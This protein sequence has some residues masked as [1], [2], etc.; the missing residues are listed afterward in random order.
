MIA[1]STSLRRNKKVAGVEDP[2]VIIQ[3]LLNIFRQLHILNDAQKA[4]FN[5]MIL[6]QPA[7]IRHMCNILPGGSLLQ[8]YIDDLEEKNGIAPSQNLSSE[9]SSS[10]SNDTILNSALAD[11]S[12]TPQNSSV[13]P[14]AINVAPL[15]IDASFIKNIATAI[16]SVLAESDAKRQKDIFVMTQALT[17]SQ[18]DSTAS[19]IKELAKNQY[20]SGSSTMSSDAAKEIANA[21]KESQLGMAQLLS[22]QNIIPANSD[23]EATE[24]NYQRPPIAFN[25]SQN[26]IE[27]IIKAQSQLFSQMAL[28][29]T[30]ELSS[31]ISGSLTESS[32][33]SNQ[34][35]LNALSE[36][37]KENLNL[38][39]H[40]ANSN[41]RPIVS[42][43]S[44]ESA[45]NSTT[46]TSFSESLTHPQMQKESPDKNEIQTP[47]NIENTISSE[48]EDDEPLIQKNINKDTEF[49]FDTK[50]S[51]TE[52][53]LESD[54]TFSTE[55]PQK[56]K[57]KKKKKKKNPN[58]SLADADQELQDLLNFDDLSS[59]DMSSQS[60][61]TKDIDDGSIL[62]DS[63]EYSNFDSDSKID[64]DNNSIAIEELDQDNIQTPTDFSQNIESIT[65]PSL[66]NISSENILENTDISEEQPKRSLFNNYI[67][68][69]DT[70]QALEQLITPF[71]NDTESNDEYISEQN[72][73]DNSEDNSFN[74]A[75]NTDYDQQNYS[76]DDFEQEYTT[77]TS[78]NQNDDTEWEW[79]YEEVPEDEA[80]DAQDDDTEW[81]WEYEEVPEDEVSDTQNDDTEWEWEYEE[82]P[83][84]EASDADWDS[85][86][87]YIDDS[88][89]SQQKFN[90]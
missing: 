53:I 8:E 57:K 52:E 17:K 72:S 19:L 11:N 38:I 61:L 50:E 2:I 48:I 42:S 56:K 73:Y 35:L 63:D 31:I 16:S 70:H 90:K 55:N 68:T 59:D 49:S 76:S 28:E 9:T 83:E 81:E 54:D 27:D 75:D 4:E 3:R 88:N 46:P 60:D 66:E 71:S 12:N 1:D 77:E 82:V 22:Q 33:I 87:D 24:N 14:A 78:N 65:Q 89:Q 25:L 69:A 21:I 86:Q 37:Q 18:Q 41:I 5:N 26:L 7:E 47:L 34:N 51:E 84:D 44:F 13:K 29:Q 62:S 67:Q 40:L 23:N 79:E 80:L 32:H 10:Y 6:S 20:N 15:N 45:T 36:F 85:S 30:K 39:K 43:A 64:M 74:T 58:I